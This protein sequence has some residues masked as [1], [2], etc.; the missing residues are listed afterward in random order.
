M[1]DLFLF[2]TNFSWTSILSS[3]TTIVINV[4]DDDVNQFSLCWPQ[5]SIIALCQSIFMQNTS[6]FPLP[7]CTSVWKQPFKL[8]VSVCETNMK[9][10]VND[11][12]S[13][14]R[15]LFKK[16]TS[17]EENRTCILSSPLVIHL[18]IFCRFEKSENK[19]VVETELRRRNSLKNKKTKYYLTTKLFWVWKVTYCFM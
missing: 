17:G 14:G 5:Q 2:M 11:Y 6:Y 7:T 15:N 3:I 16:L 12:F 4:N 13:H 1:S 10:S 9:D 18:W 8:V 19:F